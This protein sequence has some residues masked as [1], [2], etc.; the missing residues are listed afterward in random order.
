M[1]NLISLL[2]TFLLVA[3]GLSAQSPIVI[4][5]QIVDKITKEPVA[6]AHIGIPEKGIGTTSGHDG[7]FTFKVPRRY[8]S[9]KMMVSFMGYKTFEQPIS[10]VTVPVRIELVRT[11][12]E[13]PEVLVTDGNW[14][15]NIIRKAI[16]AIP[17]NY[18]KISTRHLAFYR[19]SRTD[20]DSQYIYLAEGVLNIYKKSYKSKKEGQV[21]LVEGRRINL[22]NPLD[23]MIKRGL[24]SGHMAAHRFDFVYNREDFLQERYLPVYK[25][26]LESIT[27][28]NG[29]SVYVIAFDK[30]V[31]APAVLGEIK[32]DRDRSSLEKIGSIFTK[33]KNKKSRLE[34]RMRG[35]VYID[36]ET[37]AIIRGEF[38]IT[39]EGL[40]KYD[41]YPLY[42]GSWKANSYTVNYRSIGDRWYFSD[43]F[44]KGHYGSG[45]IYSNEVKMT[46]IN[47]EKGKPLPYKDRLHRNQRFSRMTGSYDPNFWNSYNTTPLSADQADGI[48]QMENAKKAQLAFSPENMEA[49][50][51]Q[52]DSIYYVEQ[53]RLASLNEEVAGEDGESL[54]KLID[55]ADIRN[56]RSVTPS[57]KKRRSDWVKGM[58]GAGTHFIQ[59]KE[60]PI[61]IKYESGEDEIIFTIEDDI[62]NRNFEVVSTFDLEVFFNHR[63]FA[64]VGMSWDYYNSIYQ[65]RTI[66]IGAEWNLSKNRPVYFKAIAQ[67]EKLRYARKMGE[68]DNDYGKFKVDGKKINSK[69]FNVYYGSRTRNIKLSG[70]LSVE[71]MPD[72]EL[73]IRGAYHLPLGSREEIWVKE[74]KQLFRKK[75]SQA[76]SDAEISVTQNGEAFS[77]KIPDR[78]SFSVTVGLL[79]K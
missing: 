22:L 16:K 31:D 78:G 26:W 11:Q 8:V 33:K 14:A 56:A 66:G 21:S 73:Y 68:V 67:Y 27:S 59:S 39:K 15:K 44:R 20:K 58:F 77:S 60:A 34:A 12:N 61:N 13:L 18:P 45:G 29:K 38:E 43:A 37:F 10:M 74:R 55:L 76:V 2:T 52:R 17:K 51:R 62:K 53:L 63:F 40:R 41:D 23:T 50:Q 1:K 35:K 57:R 28:Y 79:F 9:S 69:S 65:D 6:Y 32:T 24:N 72:R 36:K 49:L 30:D 7:Q 64:R 25:Y 48:R 4:T 5:G 3:T 71:L 54:E 47:T 19:E 46:E 70:E 42:A 75:N